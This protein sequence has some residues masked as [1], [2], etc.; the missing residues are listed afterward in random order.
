MLTHY[1]SSIR[2]NAKSQDMKKIFLQSSWYFLWFLFVL[3][4]VILEWD[5]DSIEIGVYTDMLLSKLA[6]HDYKMYLN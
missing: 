3:Q 6:C 5:S 2:I 1:I 4:L